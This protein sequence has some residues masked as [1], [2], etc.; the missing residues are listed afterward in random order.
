MMKRYRRLTVEELEGVRP[1]FVKFLASE[2]IAA[3]DWERKL[4]S[5][6]PE[7]LTCIDEFSEK[8]WDGATGAIEC[9]EHCPST[10]NLWVFH[11][12]E[13]SAHV[14]QC[15][16]SGEA[17]AWSQGGK[18]FEPEA[19]GQEIFLLLEQGAKPCTPERFQEVHNQMTAAAKQ[20]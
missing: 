2:G 3:D 19:R 7:V 6:S 10:D 15:Q 17:L 8:F 14:I 13:R 11:F 5:D 20:A 9:L 16:K 1:E 18:Q 4:K 12:A